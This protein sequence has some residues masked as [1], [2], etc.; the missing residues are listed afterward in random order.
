VPYS[1]IVLITIFVWDGTSVPYDIL[2]YYF[3]TLYMVYA[4]CAINSC[5]CFIRTAKTRTVCDAIH[6]RNIVTN[7]KV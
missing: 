5:I 4:N 6:L 7:I 2:R 1:I 3:I